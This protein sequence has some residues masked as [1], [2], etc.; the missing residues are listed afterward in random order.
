MLRIFCCAARSVQAKIIMALNNDDCEYMKRSKFRFISLMFSWITALTIAGCSVDDCLPKEKG[1]LLFSEAVTLEK[2]GKLQE[3]YRRY[4]TVAQE[5]CNNP[6]RIQAG[7]GGLRLTR[8]IVKAYRETEA[9]L[10]KYLATNGR[11]PLTLN[12]IKHEIPAS[13]LEAF[14]GF[15]YFREGDQKMGINT[16]LYGSVEFSLRKNEQ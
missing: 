3:A 5:G 12:E 16:G 10:E 15:Q 1:S 7:E 14:N 13:S 4:S 8:V 2:N 6:E 9:V 11:Y